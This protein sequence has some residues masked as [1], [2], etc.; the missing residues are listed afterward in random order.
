MSIDTGLNISMSISIC[1]TLGIED[2]GSG[3]EEDWS[4]VN[5]R[6]NKHASTLWD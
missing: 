4:K 3:K 1:S 6:V 5:T 2:A